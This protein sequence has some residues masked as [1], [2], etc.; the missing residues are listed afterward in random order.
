MHISVIFFVKILQLSHRSDIHFLVDVISVILLLLDVTLL[1]VIRKPALEGVLSS[2]LTVS[3]D[4]VS[5][6]KH[7]SLLL[8]FKL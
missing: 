6:E 3:P 2:Y 4:C 1:H 7:I 8:V 5:S